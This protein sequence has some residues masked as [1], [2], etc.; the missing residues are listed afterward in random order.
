[1]TAAQDDF[2]L[3][4]AQDEQM[5][6]RALDLAA[7]AAEQDE[8]PVGAIVVVDGEI[9]GSG[10][11]LRESGQDATLHAEMIAIRAACARLGGWRLPHATLY[12]TLE[13]CAMC[14]GAMVNA[15]IERLVFG[16]YDPKSGCSGSVLDITTC[17][18]LNHCLQVKGGV[19]AGESAALLK[20]FFA[21]K[22]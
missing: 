6:R 3:Q 9:I 14:A 16:A 17:S 10:F 13:P 21:R 7:S 12:V 2:L 18:R 1:M 8:V 22:R 19:L 11:N 15:R 20:D 4:S 5:M